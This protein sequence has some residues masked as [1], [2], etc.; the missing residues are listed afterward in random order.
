MK[1]QAIAVLTLGVLPV[2]GVDTIQF[3]LPDSAQYLMSLSASHESR[4]GQRKASR[5]VQLTARVEI[6]KSGDGHRISITYLTH[7][8]NVTGMPAGGDLRGL[9]VTYEIDSIGKVTQ[10]Y[11][12]D[13]IV[14]RQI[15]SIGLPPAI[16][17]KVAALQKKMLS[18]Q[19]ELVAASLI[20]KPNRAG[21]RWKELQIAQGMGVIPKPVTRELT[22][23]GPMT[24]G[25]GECL[26]VE[27]T[28]Q[29]NSAE[30]VAHTL[31]AVFD[32]TGK[33]PVTASQVNSSWDSARF[34][35][36]VHPETGIIAG[37][38][39]NVAGSTVVKTGTQTAKEERFRKIEFTL[40]NENLEQR[41]L[42]AT[43]VV[44]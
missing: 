2:L 30:D 7:Y 3:A 24:C 29:Y 15:A 23:I 35:I 39:E 13:E 43:I 1:L 41:P 42:K 36:L 4:A 40:R 18:E 28:Y 27:G 34:R 10:A 22:S 26:A 8:E 20:G 12:L 44:P 14:K 11:G 5:K 38:Q 31:Q 33:E 21:M 6:S 25:L 37:Y 19:C 16:A 17:S 9:N 32:A